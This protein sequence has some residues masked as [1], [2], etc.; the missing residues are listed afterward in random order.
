MVKQ[1]DIVIIGAGPVAL[2]TVFEA[3]LLGLNCILIDNLDKPGGQC[4]EL[5]PEKPIYDI[6]GVPMQTGQQHIDALLEQIKPFAPG[7]SLGERAE[8]LIKKEDGSFDVI[9]SSSKVHNAKVVAIAGGLG[10]FEPRKPPIDNI[11]KYE[12]RG[13]EYMVKDPENFKNKKIT[14]LKKEIFQENY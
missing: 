8:K 5:Y 1:S 4:A 6:P 13:V 12:A 7:Y 9:T 2:F 11:V 10:S 14:I 3:G